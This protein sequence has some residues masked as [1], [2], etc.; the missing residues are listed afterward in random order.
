MVEASVA[1]AGIC[2]A[3]MEVIEVHEPQNPDCCSSPPQP[4]LQVEEPCAAA[5][6]QGVLQAHL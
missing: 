4:E 1:S 6:L 3:V 5:A 2:P